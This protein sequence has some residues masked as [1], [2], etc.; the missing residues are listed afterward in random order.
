MPCITRSTAEEKVQAEYLARCSSQA[1]Y[2][3]L[4]VRAP[5]TL[6]EFRNAKSERLDL[7]EYILLCRNDRLIDLGLAKFAHTERAVRRVYRRG[8]AAC[9]I[10][11]WSN[12]AAR[13]SR[14]GDDIWA[15]DGELA[16]LAATG[17]EDELATLGANF[18]LSDNLL[19]ALIGRKVPF[20]ELTDRRW[21]I[22]MIGLS[23]NPWLKEGHCPDRT[24]DDLA[25]YSHDRVLTDIWRLAST[26]PASRDWTGLLSRLLQNCPIPHGMD[27]EAEALLERWRIDKPREPDSKHYD[28][29]SSFYLRA[30][31]ADLLKPDQAFASQDRAVRLSFWKRFDPQ[32]YPRW[33][34]DMQRVLETE[35]EFEAHE[36][37]TA[38][39]WNERLWHSESTREALGSLCS[40]APDLWH[41]MMMSD[42][43]RF[44]LRKHTEENPEWFKEAVSP[45]LM[46]SEPDMEPAWA[47]LL[48]DKIN[49]TQDQISSCIQEE[50]FQ[51]ANKIEDIP[52]S[53]EP[54]WAT[55]IFRKI[56][57]LSGSSP[58][59]RSRPWWSMV[60][61]WVWLVW[62]L[63]IARTVFMLH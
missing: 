41:D 40:H 28:S 52:N 53:S 23:K 8:G 37:L 60:P 21:A 18:S 58:V 43:Y 45:S 42:H 33:A 32:Q 15:D 57:G 47:S 36:A 35:K 20:A 55:E 6:A 54:A 11:A 63:V 1:A 29:D 22:C 46:E 59:L 27:K 24:M 51:L 34:E 38:A 12:V 16:R 49:A 10:A 50:I 39:M 19:S 13:G 61:W 48:I 2:E 4:Q 26:L 5:K 3:W 44:L 9:R 14:L 25:E 62:G 17:H 31:L 30:R 56:D 7:A